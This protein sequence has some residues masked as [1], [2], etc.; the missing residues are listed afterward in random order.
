MSARQHPSWVRRGAVALDRITGQV[1]EVQ[2]VGPAYNTGHV[3][4]RDR[5]Q[6]WLRPCSGGREW[7]TTVQE[8]QPAVAVEVTR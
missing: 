4:A 6:V 5:H 2:Q 8:L 1:G 3:S 7:E